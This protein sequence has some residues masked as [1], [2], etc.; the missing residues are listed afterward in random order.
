MSSANRRSRGQPLLSK[1][2]S[3]VVHSAAV[4]P[5]PCTKT[6]G[7]KGSGA[8]GAGAGGGPLRQAASADNSAARR[9]RASRRV[10]IVEG[11]EAVEGKSRAAGSVGRPGPDRLSA[12]S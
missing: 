11:Q 4:S 10:V 3:V 12:A 8:D 2:H 9:S 1:R 5:L 6:M 7:G